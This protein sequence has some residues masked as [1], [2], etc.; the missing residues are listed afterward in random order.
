[1]AKVTILVGTDTYGKHLSLWSA[2]S[3][4]E[5]L[6]LGVEKVMSSPELEINV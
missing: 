2:L 5:V 6:L 4:L 3:P 1:M